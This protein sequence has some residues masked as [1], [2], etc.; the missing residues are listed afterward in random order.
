MHINFPVF[1]PIGVASENRYMLPLPMLQGKAVQQG[2]PTM[3]G[4]LATV[5]P[6][7][8][9]NSYPVIPPDETR[10]AAAVA[11]AALTVK[12]S[13]NPIQNPRIS[14][15]RFSVASLVPNR[16]RTDGVSAQRCWLSLLLILRVTP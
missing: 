4:S 15:L 3:I 2:V 8:G 14:H 13:V 11:A 16:E 6:A 7:V 9:I 12:W 1:H 5:G 10:M